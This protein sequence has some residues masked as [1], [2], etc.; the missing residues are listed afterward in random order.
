MELTVPQNDSDKNRYI[1][2]KSD[3]NK[4]TKKRTQG[5]WVDMINERDKKICKACI[6]WNNYLQ[7]RDFF[8]VIVDEGKARIHYHCIK[9]KSD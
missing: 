8:A 3:R 2:G 4:L 1:S 6:I 9:I 5:S 7:A